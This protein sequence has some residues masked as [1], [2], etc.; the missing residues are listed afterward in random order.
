MWVIDLV[1]SIPF[2]HPSVLVSI[3]TQEQDWFSLSSPTFSLPLPFFL[4]IWKLCHGDKD[5]WCSHLIK[6]WASSVNEIKSCLFDRYRFSYVGVFIFLWTS[7]LNSKKLLQPAWSSWAEVE[8]Y[9]GII[10]QLLKKIR[11][12]GDCVHCSIKSVGGCS[13]VEMGDNSKI[14]TCL[15]FQRH[16]EKLWYLLFS[17]LT[18]GIL[19]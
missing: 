4:I 10:Q 15:E 18:V 5:S 7:P 1:L 17:D 14:Q 13:S 6:N 2:N 9:T 16:W 3:C 12:L 8:L 11:I 19:V